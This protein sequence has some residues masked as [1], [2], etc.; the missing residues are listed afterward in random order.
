MRHTLGM[1]QETDACIVQEDKE[2]CFLELATTTDN[3]FITINSNSKTA[4]EVSRATKHVTKVYMLI[5]HL[6]QVSKHTEAVT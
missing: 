1:P 5:C 4:S 2:D 3:A 6:T